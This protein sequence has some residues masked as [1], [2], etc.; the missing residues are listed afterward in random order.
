MDRDGYPAPGCGV[1]GC[2]AGRD[3]ISGPE[4][5]VLGDSTGHEVMTRAETALPHELSFLLLAGAF[6]PDST[7]RLN[8]IDAPETG[9]FISRPSAKQ[10]LCFLVAWSPLPFIVL[11]TTAGL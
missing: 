7:V 4:R 2:G 5:C 6:F 9:E 8:S 10:L 11:H 3:G 1:P